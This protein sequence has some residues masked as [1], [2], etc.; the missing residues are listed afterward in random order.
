M[1]NDQLKADQRVLIIPLKK[2]KRVAETLALCCLAET[3]AERVEKD[4]PNNPQIKETAGEIRNNPGG[5]VELL[6]WMVEGDE[7]LD[8]P[9]VHCFFRSLLDEHRETMAKINELK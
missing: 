2:A 3:I 1:K 9:T 6:E 5:A 8:H 4:F 7:V